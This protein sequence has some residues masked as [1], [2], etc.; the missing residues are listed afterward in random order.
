MAEIQFVAGSLEESA[1]PTNKHS[2]RRITI[3]AVKWRTSGGHGVITHSTDN[4]LPPSPRPPHTHTH[5]T[6]WLAAGCRQSRSS[7]AACDKP[8]G[9]PAL[10]NRPHS[11]PPPPSS[12]PP[13]PRLSPCAV[14]SFSAWW[15][16]QFAARAG[17]RGSTCCSL[18]SH[19]VTSPSCVHCG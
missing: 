11:P 13:P 16:E 19:A 9:R 6:G 7:W 5:T 12:P 10:Y 18:S 1:Q 4:N 14:A 17:E 2:H 3:T 8:S 15:W